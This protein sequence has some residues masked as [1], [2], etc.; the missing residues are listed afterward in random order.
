MAMRTDLKSVMSTTGMARG[1]AVIAI[2]ALVGPVPVLDAKPALAQ[3]VQL[4]QV[5]VAVVAKGYRVSKLVGS[6]V[7]ND[8]NEKIGSVDDII[9]D[10]SK[11]MFAVLQVGGFLGIG[12]HLVAIPYDSLQID[13]AGKKVV[14]PGASK[15]E[16]K[17][18]TEFKYAS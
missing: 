11:V 16:L 12:K 10:R 8:K 1:A 3:G 15:D 7:T 6:S 18:L 2:L 14:L 4:I 5:D 9:I 17:K 13:E